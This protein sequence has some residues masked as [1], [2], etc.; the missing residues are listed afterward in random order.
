M[1]GGQSADVA[2]N[3]E[4]HDGP[5]LLS[6]ILGHGGDSDRDGILDD[7]DKCPDDP[8]DRDGFEDADGCPDPDNDADG[9]VDRNDKCPNIPETVNGFQD[10]DGC[11]DANIDRAK[12]AFREGAT[13]YAQGDF[14]NA[15]RYFEEAN[16]LEPN[17]LLLFNIAQASEK[18]GDHKYA[19][20]TYK[21]W[22]G[23]PS[24]S[25]ST[26]RIPVLETCP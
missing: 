11:P 12:L 10:D 24:G 3:D 4:E 1:A 15:R 9:V 21:Q 26:S 16:N 8:E 17:D 25:T 23:T 20:Q 18:Q 5:S 13:A 2:G 14:A 6:G 22:R 7:A 19:C